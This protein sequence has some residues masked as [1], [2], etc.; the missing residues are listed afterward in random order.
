MRLV[1]IHVKPHS[2]LGRAL[3]GGDWGM[4]VV[5]I[6]CE[7][8]SVAIEIYSELFAMLGTVR[9]MVRMTM[10]PAKASRIKTGWNIP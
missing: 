2:R 9:I 1:A 8:K 7:F 10:L 5:F 4:F 3:I 6:V